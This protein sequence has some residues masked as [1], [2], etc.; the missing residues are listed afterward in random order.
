MTFFAIFAMSALPLAVTL[1]QPRYDHEPTVKYEIIEV[2]WH[3]VQRVCT[4]YDPDLH[5]RMLAC[6]RNFGPLG[7]TI[8]MPKRDG[9]LLGDDWSRLLRHEKGHINGWPRGHP[10]ARLV[11]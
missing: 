5:G 4:G 11:Y 10:E 6:A 7:W 9:S 3:K 8:V 2:P 1:P